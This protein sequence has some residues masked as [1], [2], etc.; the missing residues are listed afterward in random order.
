MSLSTKVSHF[1]FSTVFRITNRLDK[2]M[3]SVKYTVGEQYQF[4]A[5]GVD[6]C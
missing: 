2:I 4:H 5:Y 1:E 6:S 3:V